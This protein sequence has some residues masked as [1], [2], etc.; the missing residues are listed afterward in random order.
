MPFCAA[1]RNS[2]PMP[3]KHRQADFAQALLNPDIPV[4]QG[5]V[6]PKGAPAPKRFAVYRNNVTVSLIEAMATAFPVIQKI[7]GA[8]FFA[9]MACDFV[10]AHPPTSPLLMFYGEAFPDFLRGFTPVAHL[11]YLPEVAQLELYRRQAY[12]AAD[13]EP[14]P[15]NFLGATAPEDLANL[16]VVFHPSLR[17]LEA[18]YPALSLWEWNNASNEA[19]RPALPEHGEAILIARPE[20]TV[21]MHRLPPG[22]I[23]FLTVLA[24]GAPLGAAAEAGATNPQFDLATCISSLLESRIAI[25]YCLVG[26]QQ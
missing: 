13:D 3:L 2:T 21:E 14:L 24:E 26:A 19:D 10:R 4:P 15:D 1:P 7:V 6:D 9:A 23:Q 16:S 12:H 20:L 11:A 8:E 25:S 18:T 17:L 5:V 22:G